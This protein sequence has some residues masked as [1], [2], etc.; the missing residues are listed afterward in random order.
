VKIKSIGDIGAVASYLRRI[1]AEVRSMRTAVVR[2]VHGAYWQDLAVIRFTPDGIIDAPLDYAPTDAEIIAIKEACKGVEWPTIRYLHRLVNLPSEISEADPSRV[3]EFR[4]E[5][6]QLIMIQV[7][8]E[9]KADEGGKAYIPWTYWSDDEWRKME[10]EGLLP[11]WG[12][13]KI[14]DNTT[15]FIHEG[16]KAARACQEMIE[17]KTTDM[18]KKLK[19]HP[20][21]EELSGAVHVGWI[22]GALSPERTDWGVLKRAGITRAYIVSDNDKPGRAAVAPIAKQLRI[23]TFHVQFT[24]EW[25]A[26]FDLYDDFPREMFKQQDKL[27]YFVGP[28]FR[29]CLH[30]ATWATDLVQNARGKPSTVLRE[31]F[32]DMW[33]YVEEADI[34]VCIEMPDIMRTEAVMNKMLSSFSHTNETSK[35]IVKAYGGRSP[36]LCYRPDVDGRIVTDG[37]TSAI[38]LHQPSLVKPMAGDPKPFLDFLDY[39]FPHQEE[40]EEMKKW[41]ATLIARPDLRMEY[42]VLLVSEHQGIGKTTLGSVILAPLIGETNVSYPNESAIVNSDFNDW[43]ANKRLAVINEIY[44]GHSW[45]AYQKL[46]SYITDKEVTVNQKYQRTYTTENW[47]HFFAC[48]NSL[49]ALKVEDDDRRWFYPEV[50]EKAWSRDKFSAFRNWLEGGGLQIIKHWAMGFGQ[51]VTPGKRAPMTARKKELIEESRSP[52][53]REVADLAVAAL[54]DEREIAFAMKDVEVWVRQSVN[55]KYFDSD[56]DLRKAMKEAGLV[57][58]EQRAFVN[59]RSQYVLMN[60]ALYRTVINMDNNVRDKGKYIASKVVVPGDILKVIM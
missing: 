51:Y 21:G 53:Q 31:N 13:D 42:G 46:K 25:P 26:T 37:P 6:G 50:T 48:S 56:Y 54:A 47:C 33:A 30:P 44:S 43:L 10:P 1:G 52:A 35:L 22:G 7:R 15:V 2:E 5:E 45:K 40:R 32:K 17:A 36:K 49:R 39:M 8:R 4:N 12:A 19:A 60:D 27:E 57:P 41:L 14:K 11:L 28:T 18:K 58:F 59:G 34:F 38:N 23:P 24:S 3:F 29:S 20:W 55:G 16:A 9:K